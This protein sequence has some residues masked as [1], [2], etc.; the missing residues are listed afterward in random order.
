MTVRSCACTVHHSPAP[1]QVDAHHIL[2]KTWGGQ[3]VPAN[4]IDLCPNHH[5]N[6]HWL[7]DAYVRAGGKP[8]PDV[9][10]TYAPFE[11]HL[12][13]LAWAQRPPTPTYTL[14]EQH[15][16]RLDVSY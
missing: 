15:G 10:R 11:R 2:P 14:K 8:N 5:H 1:H 7:L 4:L 9:W 3:S 13:A 12:A 16:F 6:V